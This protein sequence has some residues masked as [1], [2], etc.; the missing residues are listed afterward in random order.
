M[1]RW[2]RRLLYI[3]GVTIFVVVGL[4]LLL[5]AVAADPK[6]HWI[7]RFLF[8]TPGTF[9]NRGD[10]FWTYRPNT[11]I[12]EVAVYGMP[13]A[14]PPGP[15]FTVEYDCRIRSNNLGLPNDEDIAPG[16][17]VTVVLGDS[18]LV[19]QGGCPWFQRLQARR[20]QDRLVNA[21]MVGTGF[22]QW[23]HLLNFIRGQGITVERVLM[24]AISND[25]KR[26]AWTW[27]EPLL[28]C[29][30]RN[31]CSTERD[32]LWQPL[33]RQE[34]S[35]D[36]LLTRTAARYPNR[37]VDL[38]ATGFVRRYVKYRSYLLEFGQR[39]GQNLQDLATGANATA[40][41]PAAAGVIPE[42]AAAL[43]SFKALGIPVRV[44]MVPQRNE[45]GLLGEGVDPAAADATLKS[46]GIAYRWC[47]LLG[48]DFMSYD[49]H[50]NRAGYDKVVA[51]AEQALSEM[52]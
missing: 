51:C 47:P 27:P 11:E 35:Q 37:F 20:P 52:K 25:F 12:R 36:E 31:V 43:E 34:E 2:S 33:L 6:S 18:F 8:V 10:K 42:T 23:W 15:R 19:G 48:R 16:K 21:G 38:S 7:S 28:D 44:L 22:E 40:S 49:G 9:V 3:L 5:R 4:E 17:A 1:W 29:I 26:A 50:P 32:D 14:F 41:T 45:V 39:A 24:I 46:H 30:N 13:E